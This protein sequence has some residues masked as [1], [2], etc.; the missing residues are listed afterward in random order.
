MPKAAV[1][2]VDV[3]SLPPTQYLILDVLAARYRTGETLW[4]FPARSGIV[5]AAHRLAQLGLVGVKS[6]TRPKKTAAW[7]GGAGRDVLVDVTAA[8]VARGAGVG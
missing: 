8:V 2:P 7:F 4:T 3:D 1:E 6:G 5:A